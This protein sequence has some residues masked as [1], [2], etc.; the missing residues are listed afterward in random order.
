MITS[1]SKN[2]KRGRTPATRG[3]VFSVWGWLALPWLVGAIFL[4][5]SAG[6]F[7]GVAFALL[8]AGWFWHMGSTACSRCGFYGTGRC[9][10]Q[11]WVVPLL[12]KKRSAKAAS[13]RQIRLHFF[14][15]VIMMMAGIAAY[16]RCPAL[17]PL[18][19]GWLAMGWLV[20]YRPKRYH[21]L[22][23]RLQDLPESSRRGLLSLPVVSGPPVRQSPFE[24][25]PN[26][27]TG[28]AS[29]SPEVR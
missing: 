27:Q 3:L 29:R 19:L 9:G 18:F 25:S 12:W 21:A 26:Q 6:S 4:S 23:Y 14:F 2:D 11:T 17:V 28:A 1:S 8:T 5:F 10:I 7:F 13:R 15:D 20:V 24:S 22:L 16:T